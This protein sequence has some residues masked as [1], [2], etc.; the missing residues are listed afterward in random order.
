[1][2]SL[3]TAYTVLVASGMFLILA[4]SSTFAQPNLQIQR[5]IARWPVISV[6]YSIHCGAQLNLSHTVQQMTLREDGVPVTTF[7]KH[8]PDTTLAGNISFGLVLDGSGSTIGAPNQWIKA[9]AHAFVEKMKSTDEGAVLHFATSATLVQAMTAD[10]TALKGAINQLTAAGASGVY[11]AIHAGLTHVG[12]TA[13]KNRRAVVIITDSGDNSSLHSPDA[14]TALS[15]QLGIP[16]VIIGV[17]AS[18]PSNEFITLATQTG[19]RFIL[20]SDANAVMQAFRDAYELIADDFQMCRVD[21]TASCTDGTLRMVE[22]EVNGV[23][24][25]SD[26]DNEQYR[27]P[28]DTTG[29]TQLVI[30]GPATEALATKSFMVPVSISSVTPGLLHPFDMDLQLGYNCMT[31]D[32]VSVPPGSPL[33]GTSLI[34]YPVGG[35][36]RVRS[37]VTV[38][39]NGPGPLMNLHFTGAARNDSVPCGITVQR[40]SYAAGC[41][42]T[43]SVTIP[44]NLGVPPLPVITPSGRITLCPGETATLTANDGFDSYEWST[45]SSSRSIVVNSTGNYAVTVMDRAGRTATSAPVEVV[46]R[47]SPNPRL[48]VGS[49]LNLCKGSSVLVGVTATF[50]SYQWSTG[51]PTN[52]ILVTQ[53]GSYFVTVTDDHGCTWNSDTLVVTISDPNVSVTASGP[54]T[55]C[56]GEEVTLDAEMGFASYLWSNNEQTRSIVVRSSGSYF[57]KAT[58]G[59]G[60]TATS[61]TIEVIVRS[62]PVAGIIASGPLALCPGSTL[63]LEGS[64]VFTSWHWST[65]A[66]TRAIT[67]T[68]PGTYGLSVVDAFGCVSDTATVVV[69][70]EQRP[71]LNLPDTVYICPTGAVTM[72]AGAGYST[73]QWSQGATTRSIQVNNAGT[74]F[75]RVST[76]T[77]CVMYSDTVVVEVREQLKPVVTLNGSPRMCEGDSLELDGGNY[78]SWNWSTG[79]KTRRITVRSEGNYSVSVIDAYGCAGSSDPVTVTVLPAPAPTIQALTATRVC[80]GDTV[81]LVA[82]Q[83][84]VDYLWSNGRTGATIFVTSSGSYSVTV[85]NSDGCKGISPPMSVTVVP[86]PDKPSITRSG[87]TLLASSAAAY[88]WLKDGSLLVGVTGRTLVPAVSGSYAVRVFN[89]DGCSAD[90][91][92]L[93]VVSS[94]A[95][96]PARPREL[97]LYPD[98]TSGRITIS[99]EIDRGVGLEITA[100]NLLGQVVTR[101]ADRSAKGAFTRGIDIGSAPRG[102]YLLHIRY[103]D[104]VIVRRIVKT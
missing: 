55:F 27:A 97:S 67:V 33:A 48:T 91:D 53:A 74:Y 93:S 66:T 46:Y 84:F 80:Q 56:D 85:T 45:T 15:L 37:G 62:K 18:L 90:S 50:P 31:L 30:V 14:V 4:A 51:M 83:G 86:L 42:I 34:G 9:G 60:C 32:S 70:A 17:G 26:M 78:A 98:P 10:S 82:T 68:Q 69:T 47:S 38:P 104:R 76:I 102:V 6:Y 16:V 12:N 1:M 19:G 23:C 36:M 5:V 65:G 96:E 92:P 22:L 52:S 25:G 61:D 95:A 8:C 43:P 49:T 7:T 2:K 73:Y 77:G 44:V 87:D 99:G 81:I 57:V 89:A 100:T 21:Y 41:Y 94:P 3:R 39:L 20:A 28:M 35:I 71:A 40:V 101:L 88:Q 54:L 11:S 79:E 63:V 24:S 29:R 58:D 103:G 72:D 64:P 59:G 13:S 75:V